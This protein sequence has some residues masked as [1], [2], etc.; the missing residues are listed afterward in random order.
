MAQTTI[1]TQD[2]KHV[3]SEKILLQKVGIVLVDEMYQDISVPSL[4]VS[5]GVLHVYRDDNSSPGIDIWHIMGATV[6]LEYKISRMGNKSFM[7]AYGV[8]IF[9]DVASRNSAR[10]YLE[11]LVGGKLE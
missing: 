4:T 6:E 1:Q 9:G 8:T 10:K 11:G 2:L 5:Q 7:D 3:N